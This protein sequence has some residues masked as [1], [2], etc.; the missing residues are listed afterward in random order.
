MQPTGYMG[1]KP[2]EIEK[3]IN[4]KLADLKQSV[5]V[6]SS[7]KLPTKLALNRE[8]I[9]VYELLKEIHRKTP[10]MG[11]IAVAMLAF[12][13]LAFTILS[14]IYL[15]FQ[16]ILRPTGEWLA[17]T[18]LSA[19]AGEQ[20]LVIIAVIGGFGTAFKWWYKNYVLPK[21]LPDKLQKK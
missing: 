12:V 2:D 21:K 13:F 20:L 7:G 1:R 17:K 6:G 8:L 16:G 19:S 3:K 4:R 14:A 11:E 18:W 15:I 9:G 10:P 5:Q